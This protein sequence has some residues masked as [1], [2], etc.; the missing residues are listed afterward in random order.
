MLALRF[1]E[2]LY[3][4]NASFFEDAVL[5]AVADKAEVRYVLIVGTGIPSDSMPPA[6]AWCVNWSRA[7]RAAGEDS[8][9]AGLKKQVLDVMHRTGLYELIGPAQFFPSEEQAAAAI[10]Q[11]LGDAGKGELLPRPAAAPT[12]PAHR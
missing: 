8:V 1:D 12:S 4:A 10:N 5:E 7:S 6:R 2:S 11:R 9:F 3:F